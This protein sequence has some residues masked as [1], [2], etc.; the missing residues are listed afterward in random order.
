[1]YQYYNL[2]KKEKILLNSCKLHSLIFDNTITYYFIIQ[3][4]G[5]LI[6]IYLLSSFL[7]E[8][9]MPYDYKKKKTPKY[10]FTTSIQ[11]LNKIIHQEYILYTN[12]IIQYIE[13]N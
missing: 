2:M 10:L 5:L 1:M 4:Y 11:S 9:G 13:F 12:M 7:A 8:I 6:I 3:F